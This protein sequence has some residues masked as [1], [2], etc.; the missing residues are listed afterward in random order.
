[1]RRAQGFGG[2]ACLYATWLLL[3]VA[4][5]ASPAIAV[6]NCPHDDL[7][8]TKWSTG[9]SLG[10]DLSAF[11]CP[12][13]GSLNCVRVVTAWNQENAEVSIAA[14]QHI[15]LDV[16]PPKITSIDISGSLVIYDAII[17]LDVDWCVGLLSYMLTSSHRDA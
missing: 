11:G 14:N 3:G 8:L 13:Q 1:M 12:L 4:S 17:S 6:S 9:A 15:L 10:L 2:Y 16:S 5:L 7:T